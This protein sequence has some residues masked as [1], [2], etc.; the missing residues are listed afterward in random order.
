[1]SQAPP[2]GE[3]APRAATALAEGLLSIDQVLDLPDDAVVLKR[4]LARRVQQRLET[5]PAPA[6]WPGALADPIAVL[7]LPDWPVELKLRLI[8]EVTGAACDVPVPRHSRRERRARR[9]PCPASARAGRDPLVRKEKPT[10]HEVFEQTMSRQRNH[11]KVPRG[12]SVSVSERRYRSMYATWLAEPFGDLPVDAIDSEAISQVVEAAADGRKQRGAEL[13]RVCQVTFDTALVHGYCDVNVAR[14]AA[15]GLQ[16]T[17]KPTPMAS[18]PYP[19]APDAYR[20][21][22]D[23]ARR[24]THPGTWTAACALLMVIL[25]GC[26]TEE[27]LGLS[28]KEVDLQGRRLDI[29]AARRKRRAGGRFVVPLAAV[30]CSLIDAMP[31]PRGADDLV[32]VYQ[33]EPGA[34]YRPV[35]RNIPHRIARDR[36]QLSG[37]PHG[38]R[39]TLV[40]WMNEAKRARAELRRTALGHAMVANVVAVDSPAATLLEE[41]RP[42]MDDYAAYLQAEL[43]A[44]ERGSAPARASLSPSKRYVQPSD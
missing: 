6:G 7:D 42:F 35:H 1:M 43:P 11:W 37:S 27:V 32:F 22:W 41:R 13:C 16:L 38:F 25:T 34:P 15:R 30:A 19:D 26:R 8:A 12:S 14:Q 3:L 17:A 31:G 20:Q 21:V 33:P 18:V 23:F 36:L 4:L 2:S 24:T 5:L 40:T 10:F 44:S 28:W 9:S 29:P 39:S